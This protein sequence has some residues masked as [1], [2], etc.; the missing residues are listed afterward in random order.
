MCCTTVKSPF[1]T[2]QQF[3]DGKIFEKSLAHQDCIYL[4][5]KKYKKNNNIKY[6]YK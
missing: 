1:A 2:I 6:Y 5:K 3:G 4:V